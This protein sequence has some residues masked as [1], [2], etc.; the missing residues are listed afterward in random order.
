[1]THQAV[2][3]GQSIAQELRK[4]WTSTQAMNEFLDNLTPQDHSRIPPSYTTESRRVEE[5]CR[6]IFR[7][8]PRF[9]HNGLRIRKN[10]GYD[11][12][13]VERFTHPFG[14]SNTSV[15]QA[16][17][18]VNCYMYWVSI[19]LSVYPLSGTICCIKTVHACS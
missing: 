6:E 13:W 4:A 5:E 18:Q 1:M 7:K 9:A 12:P 16:A 11:H 3:S 17:V 14:I 15:E 10:D 8:L 19:L 2:L